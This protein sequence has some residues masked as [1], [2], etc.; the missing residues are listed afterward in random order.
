PVKLYILDGR[1]PSVISASV[2]CAKLEVFLRMARIPHSVHKADFQEAPSGTVPYIKHGSLILG[3]STCITRY[4]ERTFFDAATGQRV[5]AQTPSL[6]CPTLVPSFALPP[7]AAALQTAIQ[8]L[9]EDYIYTAGLMYTFLPKDSWPAVKEACF[10][11]LPAP[12]KAIIPAVYRASIAKR[13]W[14]QG[15][16]RLDAGD[17]QQSV[18]EAA[19]AVGHLVQQQLEANQGPFMTGAAPCMLDALLFS[20]ADAALPEG[21][22]GARHALANATLRQPGLMR[23]A[24]HV[25]DTYYATESAAMPVR[26]PAQEA[27]SGAAATTGSAVRRRSGH[28]ST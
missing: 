2:F 14:L 1:P 11:D 3:D 6:G 21:Y 13:C 24:Q 26:F 5:G 16:T 19:D 9:V 28:S 23:L 8:H 27:E 4:L 17:T 10:G 25:R 20:V 22:G 18:E 15:L 7:H 12:L